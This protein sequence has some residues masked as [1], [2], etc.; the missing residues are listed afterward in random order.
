MLLLSDFN[1]RLL[2]VQLQEALLPG[3]SSH[4]A[5]QHFP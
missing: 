5:A 4:A 2:E 3:A 1:G